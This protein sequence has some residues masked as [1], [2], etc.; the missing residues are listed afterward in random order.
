MHDT[1]RL[2]VQSYPVHRKYRQHGSLTFRHAL[3]ATTENFVLP[4]SRDE[5]VH[6]KGPLLGQDG[7]ATTGR[8]APA[9]GSCIAYHVRP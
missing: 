4:L 7:R 8:S 3:R 2:H 1:L 6:G 5:V 9:C